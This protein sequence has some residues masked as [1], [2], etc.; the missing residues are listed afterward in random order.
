MPH[1]MFRIPLKFID[2]HTLSKIENT[3]NACGTGYGY[4]GRVGEIISS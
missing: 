1:G 3:F 4:D 2:H